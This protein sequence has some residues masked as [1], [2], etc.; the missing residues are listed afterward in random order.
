MKDSIQSTGEEVSIVIYDSPLP[1]KYFTVKKSFL[2]SFLFTG[3]II[4]VTVFLSLLIWAFGAQ[5]KNA[6]K[7][8][9]PE[10]I[11]KDQAK[12]LELEGAIKELQSTNQ[13][14]TQKLAST[15][16]TPAPS[17]S[18]SLVGVKK[19]YGMQNLIS[20]NLVNVDHLNFKI[21][22]NQA[23]LDFQIISSVQETRISGHILVFLVSK[24]Q[25]I[26]YP[27]VPSTSLIEGLKYTQGE[28]FS[29]TRLRPTRASFSL[30]QADS[31]KF[32]IYIFS[33]E[34]DLIYLKETQDFKVEKKS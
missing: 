11:N 27:E 24:N 17:E 30:P 10:L 13:T 34:G 5:F 14:L 20:K 1:P 28:A 6:A 33:R 9:F 19:P 7:P 18:I 15:P 4:V 3:P 22:N 21:I 16:E 29:V 12:I 2:K 23:Q 8:K 25:F 32:L 31:V 26:T